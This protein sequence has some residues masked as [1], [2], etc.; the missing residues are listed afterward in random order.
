MLLATESDY[1]GRKPKLSNQKVDKNVGIDIALRELNR[2][3]SL[4]ELDSEQ[5]RQLSILSKIVQDYRNYMQT[6]ALKETNILNK[7]SDA[8]LQKLAELTQ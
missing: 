2:L 7:L 4:P 6:K 3:Q 8:E 1:M 5:I